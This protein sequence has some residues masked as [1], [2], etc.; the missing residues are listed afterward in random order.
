MPTSLSIPTPQSLAF[1]PDGGAAL[2]Y[3]A[4]RLTVQAMRRAPNLTLTE[5]RDQIAATNNYSGATFISGY[6][7][8]R[9]A[10]KSAFINRIINGEA[11]FHKLIQP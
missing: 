6:D 2:G 7:H 4:L 9:H 8:N 3:D 1:P 10:T 11:K 5:I